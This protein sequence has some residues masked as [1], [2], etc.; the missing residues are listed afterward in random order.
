MRRFLLLSLLFLIPLL[1]IGCTAE[2]KDLTSDAVFWKDEGI[3]EKKQINFLFAGIDKAAGNT[4]A[5]M[6]ISLRPQEKKISVLQIPRDTFYKGYGQPLRVNQILNREKRGSSYKEAAKNTASRLTSLFGVPIDHYLFIDLEAFSALVDGIGG[7]PM[8]ISSPMYYADP[9][10]HLV[11]DL[12]AG[13]VLL[14]GKQAEAFVRF[15]SEYVTGDLGRLDAQKMF[16]A[17]FFDTLIEK[18]D[19][20][21]AT[22]L[23]KDLLGKI[24][25]DL[26]LSETLELV[27]YFGA[28]R[29]FEN[30]S[31]MTLPGEAT[32]YANKSGA[33]Y[34]IPYKKSSARLFQDYF[35]GKT[36]AFDRS[37]SMTDE[38]KKHFFNIYNAPDYGFRVYGKED[39]QNMK[40][41]RKERV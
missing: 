5:M 9:A 26:S 25:T 32:R 27:R 22:R 37:G 10:Q 24:E 20:K 14:N 1:F 30:I 35:G 18:P 11:I 28:N 2:E 12:P 41:P 36:N 40:I 15:R 8:H 6:L 16:L 34:Y 3:A 39:L 38:K 23:Y 33:W 31:F 13:D 4:D 21:L 29:P 19:I 17:A 7:V